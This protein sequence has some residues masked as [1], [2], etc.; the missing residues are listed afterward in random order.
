MRGGRARLPVLAEISGLAAGGD[1]VWSLR[2]EDLERL[3]AVRERLEG[4]RAVL[5]AGPADSA[6][7]LAVGL[8]AAACAA[9]LRA[10][11][12]E[13]DLARPRLAAD[14][15]LAEAPGLH[16]YLRWEATPAQVLQPLT[17]AGPAARPGARPLVCVCAGR[18]APDPA[19]LLGLQSFRHIAQKLRGA[20]DLLLIAGPP[21]DGEV[22]ALEAVARE[23]DGLLAAIAAEQASGRRGRLLGKAV[24]RLPVDPL[25]AVVLAD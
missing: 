3:G 24:G 7:L 4:R 12:L 19:I 25:G 14:L 1:R 9:G 23:S 8:G 15:G 6:R 10:A 18:A 13:C 16:E 21:L 5:V 2:R 20:Y 11:L 17:L 22:G